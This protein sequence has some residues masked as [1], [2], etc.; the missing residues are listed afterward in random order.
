[1]QKNINTPFGWIGG[2]SQLTSDIIKKMPQHNLYIEV[3]GGSLAVLYAKNNRHSSKYR[4]I[5]NDI[6]SDLVNLH[7]IIQTRPESLRQQL[8]RMLISREVF[9]AIRRN[10]YK[11]RNDI[12]KAAFYFYLLSQSFGSKGDNFAMSAK[13]KRP[14]DIY[15]SFDVWSRRLKFVTIEN[16]SFA[17]LI[18]QYDSPEAFFYCDPPYV[19]TEDYYKNTGGFGIDEHTRLRDCL[20]DI[21]GKFLVSYNDCEVVRDLYKNFNIENTKQIKYT[22]NGKDSKNISE[23]FITNYR[24][25]TLFF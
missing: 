9:Y 24:V 7:R 17:E 8:H 19:G 15:K 10:R 1:M 20:T 22:L 13:T 12:E 2:K 11:P 23:V 5:V 14:K 3:F 6:N 21:K 4:E 16:M 18:A 25:N